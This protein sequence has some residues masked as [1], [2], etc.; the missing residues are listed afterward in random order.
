MGPLEAVKPWSTTGVEGPRRFLERVYRFYTEI[1]NFDASNM[2]LEKLYH[3]TV[4]KVTED[5]TNLRFNT[6]ISQMMIFMNE[7]YKNPN[8]PLE[9]LEGFL[10]LL[11]PIAPHITEELNEQV[12][13]G[14]DSL[15]NSEW[16]MYDETKTLEDTVTFVVSVNGKMRDKIM[17]DASVSDDE[18]KALALQSEK[19]LNFLS[20]TP[21]KKIIIVS[22]KIVNIVI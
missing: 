3:Q 19:V 7:C 5:Y 2:T 9:F 12:L 6:A 11:N 17:A 15:A 4:K 10:K 20:N 8:I 22:K 18:M 13:N 16:P 14:R 21:I 1:A